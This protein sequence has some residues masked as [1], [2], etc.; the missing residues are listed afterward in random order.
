MCFW[1]SKHYIVIHLCLCHTACQKLWTWSRGQQTV[2]YMWLLPVFLNEVKLIHCYS[3]SFIF[4]LWVSPLTL[5]QSI[6]SNINYVRSHLSEWWPEIQ[7]VAH[8]FWYLRRDLYLKPVFLLTFLSSHRALLLW[9]GQGDSLSWHFGF[10]LR[11]VTVCS[12]LPLGLSY[13]IL[14]MP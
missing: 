6:L 11:E 2:T 4:S 14:H 10:L 12:L 13:W 7:K 8:S 1:C 9:I 3:Y 5:S